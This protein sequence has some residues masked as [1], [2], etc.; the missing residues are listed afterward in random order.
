MIPD[1]NCKICQQ[2]H[3]E[4]ISKLKQRIQELEKEI[5]QVAESEYERGWNAAINPED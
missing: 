3:E 2:M 5:E 1:S 4:E